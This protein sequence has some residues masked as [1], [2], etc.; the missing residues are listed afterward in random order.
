[1]SAGVR[2][3]CIDIGSNTT[4]L[5]VADR[6]ERQLTWIHQERAFTAIGAEL[7]A[8]GRLGA[9]KVGEVVAVVAQQLAAAQALG[10]TQLRAVAT[11][12]IRQAANGLDL[13]AAIASA[14]GLSVD[15]LSD[16]EEARLAFVGVAGTLEEPAG[17]PL[18]VIDVGGGSSE[19]VVGTAPDKVLWWASL[20]IGSTVLGGPEPTPDPPTPSWL[21]ESRARI[22]AEL[23]RLRAPTPQLAVAAGGSAT[24]LGRIT[25]PVLD[26]TSLARALAVLTA[27]PA[28]EVGRRFGIDPQRARLLPAGLLIL[29]A[30]AKL[31]SAPLRVGRGG[32][33]EGVLL[34][35]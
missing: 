19:L 5:L 1:M 21:A 7:Q 31:F 28:A 17:D 14:T 6:Q 34:E 10:A 4:R 18:G 24:S 8:R 35:A 22:A 20:S 25:G 23:A 2:L 30:A 33:R 11:A 29:E 16:L 13:T 12:A 26:T 15:I 3:A 9:D 27:E 32:I